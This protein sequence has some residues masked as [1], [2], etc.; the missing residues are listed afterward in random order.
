MGSFGGGDV[1]VRVW[2]FMHVDAGM[3]LVGVRVRK[4][5]L[6]RIGEKRHPLGLLLPHLRGIFFCIPSFLLV[7]ADGIITVVR[8][9]HLR[10]YHWAG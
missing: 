6:L 3:G 1:T 4:F 8:N 5:L 10:L 9:F 2:I 7:R